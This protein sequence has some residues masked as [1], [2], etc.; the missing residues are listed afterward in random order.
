MRQSNSQ[1]Q[2][3]R[4]FVPPLLGLVR[5]LD[6]WLL[7]F[8]TTYYISKYRHIENSIN[9][10]NRNIGIYRNIV[11]YRKLNSYSYV[12]KFK[13]E[14][15]FLPGIS[16]HTRYRTNS[17]F[18]ELCRNNPQLQHTTASDIAG[19]WQGSIVARCVQP[20]RTASKQLSVYAWLPCPKAESAARRL[21]R[22]VGPV[23][24]GNV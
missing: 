4:V 22:A 14:F 16:D 21:Q 3:L 15:Y 1:Q 13:S 7:K 6:R 5:D 23:K 8:E 12:F 9:I 11:L 17:N 19:H 18:R 10:S 2:Q 20:L 24:R